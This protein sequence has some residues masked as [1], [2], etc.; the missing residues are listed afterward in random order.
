MGFINTFQ[1]MSVEDLKKEVIGLLKQAYSDGRITVETL[2]RRL[3]EATGAGDKE[4]LIALVSDIPVPEGEKGSAGASNET[5]A[6]WRT[7]DRVARESQSF[8]AVLGSSNRIGRWQPAKT[9][10]CLSLMGS[11]KLDFREAEFPRNG[12]H[13]N[14]ACVM[15]SIELI[16]PP[17]VNVDLSGIPLLGSMDNKSGSGDPDAPSITIRGLT[18][19]GSVEVKRKELKPNRPKDKSSGFR[20][21]RSRR[22]RQKKRFY[23]Y[24]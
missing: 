22:E 10:T 24:E 16:I 7:N 18:I 19:M 20:G 3:K 15:G 23:D 21:R 12:V 8:F 13:I 2:E 14:S 4:T 17:G 1:R 11:I 6:T 9:I 5:E